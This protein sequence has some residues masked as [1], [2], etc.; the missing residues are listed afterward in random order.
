M[1]HLHLQIAPNFIVLYYFLRIS[2]NRQSQVLKQSFR[3]Y[4]P[5]GYVKKRTALPRPP[6]I[7]SFALV[8]QATAN[9]VKEPILAAF[10]KDV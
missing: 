1:F 3:V 4:G 6:T 7:P 2:S 10:R 5:V 8:Q 9:I